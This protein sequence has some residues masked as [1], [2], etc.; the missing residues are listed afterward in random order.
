MGQVQFQSLDAAERAL[1]TMG[2]TTGPTQVVPHPGAVGGPAVEGSD[3]AEWVTSCTRIVYP[4]P[5][6]LVGAKALWEVVRPVRP[7]RR[8]DIRKVSAQIALAVV[9]HPRGEEKEY[10]AAL[11]QFHAPAAA[12]RLVAQVDHWVQT[13]QDP[14]LNHHQASTPIRVYAYERWSAMQQGSAHRPASNAS[15]PRRGPQTIPRLGPCTPLLSSCSSSASS[16]SGRSTPPTSTHPLPPSSTLDK[17]PLRRTSSIHSREHQ[18]VPTLPTVSDADHQDIPAITIEPVLRDHRDVDLLTAA[19]V[20]EVIEPSTSGTFQDTATESSTLVTKQQAPHDGARMAHP[21][22]IA[23]KLSTVQ[24]AHSYPTPTTTR[25]QT[26]VPTLSVEGTLISPSTSPAS[27]SVPSTTSV[28]APS[29][30]PTAPVPSN[31]SSSVPPSMSPQQVAA[32]WGQ[33]VVPATL[34]R[35]ATEQVERT[36][37]NELT[38]AHLSSLPPYVRESVILALLERGVRALLRPV[39]PTAP[40]ASATELFA[41][42]T[43]AAHPTPHET[44][45]HDN[46]SPTT[47][48]EHPS[49]AP[50]DGPMID[51]SAVGAILTLD[52]RVAAVSQGIAQSLSGN[53]LV[54]TLKHP[55][56]LAQAVRTVNHKVRIQQSVPGTSSTPCLPQASRFDPPFFSPV[57]TSPPSD[58]ARAVKAPHASDE[59]HEGPTKEE[60][61]LFVPPKVSAGEQRVL[62]SKVQAAYPIRSTVQWTA[63]VAVL[64]MLPKS[65][66]RP[67][68]LSQQRLHETLDPIVESVPTPG[69]ESS[70]ATALP[71]DCAQAGIESRSPKTTDTTPI[72]IRTPKAEESGN[73]PKLPLSRFEAPDP[74]DGQ[75]ATPEHAKATTGPFTTLAQLSAQEVD[76]LVGAYIGSGT[77]HTAGTNVSKPQWL[78]GLDKRPIPDQKQAVGERIFPLVKSALIQAGVRRPGAKRVSTYYLPVHLSLPLPTMSHVYILN[79][80]H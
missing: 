76:Q 38:Q 50:I 14:V 9:G 73:T 15:T 28:K 69:G 16:L 26:S 43:H 35:T 22:G 11:V 71:K 19:K 51:N 58:S 74:T 25:A 27:T 31:N 59:Q 41:A 56:A 66:R 63:A 2:R 44:S 78:E 34:A 61:V 80:E 70:K 12:V 39:G 55:L 77:R 68:L 18:F 48:D 7:I 23:P 36:T 72:P 8:L 29:S 75:H 65:D 13:H 47:A 40:E 52:A 30:A 10:S 54:Y 5:M 21:L 49:D 60:S 57:T 33:S 4:L 67:L 46:A 20:V 42:A 64:R 62:W 3:P 53:A 1:A 24:Q 32:F 79:D 17:P 45:P 6:G 37:V